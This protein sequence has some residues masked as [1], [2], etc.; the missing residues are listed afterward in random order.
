MGKFPKL[1]SN[2]E[3]FFFRMSEWD[4]TKAAVFT[5]SALRPEEF[6]GWK[7]VRF[8]PLKVCSRGPCSG[9]KSKG[10]ITNERPFQPKA[11]HALTM[12]SSRK[13]QQS[14][15]K[16]FF[17]LERSFLGKKGSCC[18]WRTQT[19]EFSAKIEKRQ[20]QGCYVRTM[21]LFFAAPP[22]IWTFVDQCLPRLDL[23]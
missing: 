23:L 8:Q 17:L 22:R 12:T 16:H 19:E 5:G 3:R 18:H 9:W 20:E 2:K 1:K 13:P 6:N 4:K 11:A 15:K 21:M 7:W 10:W 14:L